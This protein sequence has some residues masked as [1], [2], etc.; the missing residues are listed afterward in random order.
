MYEVVITKTCKELF[1]PASEW[2]TYSTDEMSF[3]TLDELKEYLAETYGKCKR[4]KMYRDPAGEHAGYIYCFV[5]ADYSHSPVEKWNEQDWVSVYYSQP[6]RVN[7]RIW[8]G[9]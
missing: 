9:R 8:G 1:A 5:D 2:R 4:Q 7:P 6:Q 3:N